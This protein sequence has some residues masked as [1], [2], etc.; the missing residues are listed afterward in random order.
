M[1]GKRP[2]ELSR[3][4]IERLVQEAV[5]EGAEIELKETLP[6]K[7]ADIDPWFSGGERIGDRA[8]NEIL[9]EIIAFANA[10]GG[11]LV[12]G[13]AESTDK[14]ARA[15][16]I[17]PLPQCADLAE[18]LRLQCRDCI[19]PQVPLIEVAGVPTEENGCGVVVF[20]VPK[21]Q[22]GPHRHTVTRECYTRRADR[23]E[24]MTMREIQDLT[25]LV[26][27]GLAALEAK[28][29]VRREKF[30]K[31]F[32]V[33]VADRE[34][35]Y[36]VRATLMPL[37]PLYIERVHN[38]DKVTP[39]LL[40]LTG[41]VGEHG[42]YELFVPTYGEQWCPIMRGTRCVTS[43]D[44][45]TLR[46]EAFCDGLI[47]Y[48]MLYRRERDQPRI[49][50]QWIFGLV[51][52]ALCA[53]ERFRRAAD[54]PEV[55]YGLEFELQVIGEELPVGPY[56]RNVYGFQFGPFPAGQ[57]LFPR[58]SIGSPDEFART[59][60]LLERDFWHTAGHDTGQGI[61]VNYAAAFEALGLPSM[62]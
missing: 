4:D 43:N 16:K 11:T 36:G 20:R 22:M 42:P 18:R 48:A 62:N 40:T 5:Q 17:V 49:F 27:R 10:H 19:E 28:F 37:T 58:Y 45:L 61:E 38:N 15:S 13:I 39:P 12:L 31:E 44:D 3:S 25:L 21:S 53:V 41:M 9:E 59:T 23:T 54:A 35:A 29:E 24:K 57:S 52:N 34:P 30:V 33:F 2:S 7:G 46:R 50:P 26:E 56:G 55:E 32:Q 1:F 47:E 60:T 8:R 6:A 14:P 51:T